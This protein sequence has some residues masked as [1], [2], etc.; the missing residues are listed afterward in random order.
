MPQVWWVPIVV[1]LIGLVGVVIPLVKNDKTPEPIP[2]TTF[3]YPIRVQEKDSEAKIPNAKITL[4]VA[5]KAPL[6]EITDSNGFARI[7]IAS[8]YANKPGK[9]I[10]EATDYEQYVQ[11]IDLIEG[12][13][14][15]V[16]QLKPVPPTAT[17]MPT[18]LPTNTPMATATDTPSSPPTH[19]STSTVAPAPILTFTP[20]TI[21]SPEEPGY[22]QISLKSIT[23]E[24][25]SNGYATPPIGKVELSGVIFDLPPGQNSV[26]TQAEPLPEFPTRVTLPA[27]ISE[28]QAVYLLIT[29][30]N[31]FSHFDGE[32]TGEI[33]LFFQDNDS[34]TVDLVAGHNI[35]EWKILDEVTISTTTSKMMKEVWR[36]DSNFGGVGIIDMLTIELPSKY[37]SDYLETIEVVD[38]SIETVGSKDPAI[39]IIGVT[40][41]GL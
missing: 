20:Q 2:Q 11:N 29:G 3:D 21:P 15:D 12:T 31:V 30:G 16:I 40:V 6:D 4:E 32:K 33:H 25:T 8:S 19:T 5:D 10:V 41:K 22:Q 36:T 39:N 9:I 13:L 7:R 37:H 38:T 26:T 1:A 14:P 34:V 18:S 35:R 23:N 27:K 28:P 24:S 17:L